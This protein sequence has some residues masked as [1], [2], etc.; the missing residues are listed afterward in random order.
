MSVKKNTPMMEQY[1]SIK[2]KYHDAILFYRMGD[3]YE[4]FHG[5]AKKAAALLEITLTSR[6]K[7]QGTPIPMCGVPFRA[8]DTYI[9]K[10]IEKGCK[11]AVCEQMEDASSTKGLVKREVVRV[12]TPGMI[13][14][15]ELLD[16]KSNNFLLS[17]CMDKNSAGLS[18]LDISTGMFRTTETE[19]QN[20]RFPASLIDEAL[21]VDAREI[22]LPSFFK[23][24]PAFNYIK[25]FFSDKQITYIEKNA[26]NLAKAQER[27][28][29]KFS[30]RSLKGFGCE[31]LTAGIC[32]AG[33]V[34]FYVEETQLQDSYHI[35][36]LTKYDLNNYMIIDDRSCKNLELLKNIQS[37]DKKGTLLN[38][39]DKTVTAMG[40]R[41]IKSWLRYPLMDRDHIEKRLLAVNE[42]KQNNILRKSIR[43]HLKSVYDLERLGSRISMG[44]GNARDLTSLKRSLFKLPELFGELNKLNSSLFKGD[45]IKD[46]EKIAEELTSLAS[47]I[48]GAIREDSPHTLNDGGLIKDGY[49]QELDEV[50]EIAR[51][52]KAW[53][54]KASVLEKK[55]TGLSSLKIK[56]NKV[57]G[58]FIEV[59][60][61]QS[62]SVPDNYIRKQTL[63]NAERFITDELKEVESKVLNAQEKRSALEYLI[64][65]EIRD[66]I[67]KKTSSIL[68]M[69]DFLAKVDTILSLAEV[70]DENNYA[71]PEINNAQIT[72]IKEGRHPVVEKMV[73][74]ERYVPNCIRLD[75][76]N[77]QVLIITGPNMAGKST[78]LRQVALTVLM[79]QMGSFVPAQK[80]SLCIIDRIFTRVGALDN[81]SQGQSTFMVEMEE[82]A[83]IVN[84][85]TENSLVIL[86]EIGRGTSTFDGMSI[87]WAVAQYL[88]DLNGKGVK[89]LFATHYHE[90]IKLDKTLPRV[91]NFN[92]AV[93]EFNDNII[94][95][96]KLVKGGTN[97]SYG[98]QVARLAGVPDKIIAKAKE[99]LH[100]A[101]NN[102]TSSENR[103][104]VEENKTV[105]EQMDLF[106]T[107]NHNNKIIAMIKEVD[108]SSI[109]PVQALNILNNIQTKVNS[110]THKG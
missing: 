35:S 102:G 65:C 101:E 106:K 32:A 73:Q 45:N 4:M 17:L 70:A 88:H 58:Y 50:L 105:S 60:K 10:L 23:K 12:I 87:A 62:K 72:E 7:S 82:T 42:A 79:A 5:D 43:I 90:L 21:R 27:L 54:A 68:I 92:I 74:G 24:N 46:R 22:L 64:F 1:L 37:G 3:F 19:T 83:N 91:K 18:F 47:L 34:I 110:P 11:V 71:K 86:D 8:A 109:T 76:E 51:D 99:I 49:N 13:L 57:F 53:I 77:N 100:Y 20:G 78:V 6:N 80:A 25:E 69:A 29:L 44:H 55:K 31:N 93:K 48:H 103:P 98:I 63:V 104:C 52:G 9:A 16:K 40:S 2:E 61:A 36:N 108:I 85:A 94:F 33:A 95:L 30:T 41:L 89:T 75:N 14:N 67:V 38:I 97:K 66:K 56:F 81:L 15:E 107:E 28:T 26:F 84:N 59:S 96:R 39:L